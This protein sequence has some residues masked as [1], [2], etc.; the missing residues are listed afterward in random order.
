MEEG[1]D[2]PEDDED[3]AALA[4]PPEESLEPEPGFEP[5]LSLLAA[6]S[7]DPAGVLAPPLAPLPELRE[8]VL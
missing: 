1:E 8:S 5:A 3:D 6:E 7:A 2:D 4:E